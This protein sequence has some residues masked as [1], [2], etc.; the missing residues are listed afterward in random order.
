MSRATMLWIGIFLAV[1]LVFTRQIPTLAALDSPAAGSLLQRDGADP[2][3]KIADDRYR[4]GTAKKPIVPAKGSR[5]FFH[6]G[7]LEKKES[8]KGTDA[9]RSIS[10]SQKRVDQSGCEEFFFSSPPTLPAAKKGHR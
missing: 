7:L 5:R 4:H 3:A 8:L 2:M 6:L 10:G 1:F 9:R